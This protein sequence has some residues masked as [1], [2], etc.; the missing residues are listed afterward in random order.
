MHWAFRMSNSWVH[1]VSC[2][3]WLPQVRRWSGK[4][5]F[6]KVREMSGNFIL[7]QGKLAF[8]RKVRENWNCSPNLMPSKVGRN[9]SGQMGAK[10][11]CDRRLEAATISEILHL[12]GQGNLTFIREKSGKSQGK[13]GEFWKLMPVATTLECRVFCNY[14]LV[15]PLI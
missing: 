4:K 15:T 9:I 12:F 7:G 10:D 6:F 11:Y 5:K 1:G 14:T 13:V 3:T 2:L 8:W